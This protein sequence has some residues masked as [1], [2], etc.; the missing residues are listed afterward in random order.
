MG[1]RT[2]N[3]RRRHNGLTFILSCLRTV[4]SELPLHIRWLPGEQ[5]RLSIHMKCQIGNDI[6]FPLETVMK[7]INKVLPL[8][9]FDPNIMEIANDSAALTRLLSH[10]ISREQPIIDLACNSTAGI[11]LR[12]AIRQ[13]A[14]TNNTGVETIQMDLIPATAEVLRAAYDGGWWASGDARKLF[15][16]CNMLYEKECDVKEIF[17]E[18]IKILEAVNPAPTNWKSVI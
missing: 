8:A 2:P 10:S 16:P 7:V 1:N 18:R 9:N 6:A 14:A 13:K 17:M 5:L 12:E 11:P 4:F 15:A 3:S